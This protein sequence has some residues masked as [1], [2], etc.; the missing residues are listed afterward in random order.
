MVSFFHTINRLLGPRIYLESIMES[1]CPP[2]RRYGIVGVRRGSTAGPLTMTE[3]V[4]VLYRDG[5]TER[6]QTLPIRTYLRCGSPLDSSPSDPTSTR[7]NRIIEGTVVL[8]STPPRP[9]SAVMVR[10]YGTIP[11]TGACRAPA[12]PG[13]STPVRTNHPEHFVGLASGSIPA[14]VSIISVSALSLPRTQGSFTLL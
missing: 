2:P 6:R 13:P 9:L 7:F 5:P 4:T 12:R 14:S 11:E 8:F 1:F 3:N 10:E